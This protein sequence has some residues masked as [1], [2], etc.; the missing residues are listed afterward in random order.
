[1]T[2]APKEIFSSSPDWTAAVEG[3]VRTEFVRRRNWLRV[4]LALLLLLMAA[5]LVLLVMGVAEVT[6]MRR[7]VE[8][9]VATTQR[10]DVTTSTLTQQ[11]AALDARLARAETELATLTASLRA[12]AD[13]AGAA[14]A[15][16]AAPAP[17]P[18]RRSPTRPSA[19][20]RKVA[21]LDQ[22]L[23]QVEAAASASEAERA[24]VDARL[25]RLDDAVIRLGGSIGPQSAP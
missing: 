14:S 11:Q 24:R 10:L 18:R 3:L 16:V 22:R 8:P 12:Q 19:I 4:Y 25:Q 1:M 23:R 7:S 20:E 5:T 15:P 21:S 6:D 17:A 9:V 2:S 13:P